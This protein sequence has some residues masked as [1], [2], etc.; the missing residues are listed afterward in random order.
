MILRLLAA[1]CLQDAE[2]AFREG[3]YAEAAALAEKAL[4]QGRSPGMLGLLGA[5]RL[6]S[7]DPAGAE[8]ALREAAGLAG[9]T[10]D[11]HRW[12][13]RAL[14]ETGRLDEAVASFEKA[15]DLLAAARVHA[16]REDWVPAEAALRRAE[17]TAEALELLAHVMGRTGRE[18]EAADVFRSLA[19]RAPS[20][21]RGWLRVGQAEAAARRP[22]RAIDALETARRLGGTE[23]EA[24]RL[25]ADLYLQ[26]QMPREAAAAYRALR[27]PTADDFLRLGHAHLRAGEPRSAVEAFEKAGPR[28]LLPR[29]QLAG[30][31]EAARALYAE[32]VKAT[33]EPEP[34]AARGASEMKREAWAAAAEALDEAVRRG[35]RTFATLYNR[36]LALHSAGRRD[37]SVAALKDALRRHPLDDRFRA[38]LRRMSP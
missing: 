10:P 1:L 27:A 38:L 18:A 28:G 17:A 14:I 22:G 2:A 23:A 13:G 4:G 12:L 9:A 29:A 5:A 11:L 30:D 8:K 20:D 3:R 15:G 31:A 34:A 25:L 7:G 24:L 6:Q 26:E 32:A 36:A 33:D 37:E 19:R 35:D 16:R 21:P